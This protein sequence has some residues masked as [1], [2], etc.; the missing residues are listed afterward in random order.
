MK[1]NKTIQYY[2]SQFLTSYLV[3]TRGL[4]ENTYLAYKDCFK[5]MILFYNDCLSIPFNKMTINNITCENVKSFID[6]LSKQ[7]LTASSCNHRLSLVKSFCKYILSEEPNNIFELTKILNIKRKKQSKTQMK[8]LTANQMEL[9]LHKPEATTR[10]GYKHMLILTV[11]YDTG[12]RV[13]ELINIKVSDVRL[14]KPYGINVIGKGNKPRFI[15]I[16]EETNKLLEHYIV[17]ENFNNVESQNQYLFLDKYKKQFT[18]EGI[19]YILN[20]YV[21]K[22]HSENELEFPETLSPHCIRHTK[23]MIMLE[24]GCNLI[25]IRDILGH[26]HIKTTEIYARTNSKQ[27]QDALVLAQ[28]KVK[29]VDEKVANYKED[30]D[31][32]KWLNELCK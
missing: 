19:T 6:Y 9:L 1:N 5:K 21:S 29:L 27:I 28:S 30:I 32:M 12:A 24:A 8:Y 16:S 11:L 22:L 10:N 13:S 31:L 15:P 25:Y 20:K 3:N 23:A 2:I 18:R 17:N 14:E 26:E 7:G 4:S